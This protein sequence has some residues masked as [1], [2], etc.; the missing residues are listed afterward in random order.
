MWSYMPQSITAGQATTKTSAPCQIRFLLR[1]LTVRPLLQKHNLHA[2]TMAAASAGGSVDSE[3]LAGWEVMQCGSPA[4][5]RGSAG[6]AA[7]STAPGTAAPA[8][9]LAGRTRPCEEFRRSAAGLAVGG[10]SGES[11]WDRAQLPLACGRW[12]ISCSVR[13]IRND[14]H[15]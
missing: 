15:C 4:E 1:R 14:S 6:A 13:D 8:A 5:P 9:R 3:R 10:L 11:S 7:P 12:K 2:H